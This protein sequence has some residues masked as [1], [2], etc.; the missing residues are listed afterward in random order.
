[1]VRKPP[2]HARGVRDAGSILGWERSPGEGHVNERVTGRNARGLQ[3][4]EI[5]CKCQTFFSLFLKWQ[6]ETNGLY[7]FPFSVQFKERIL[8]KFC[9]ARTT[10]GSTST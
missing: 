2:A 10:A 6:E 5:G 1:M 7:F 9:V 3:T 8:L 4:E